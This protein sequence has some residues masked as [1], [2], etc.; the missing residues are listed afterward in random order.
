MLFRSATL[1]PPR[2]YDVADL[3]LN[4]SGNLDDGTR[5][6]LRLLR[7]KEPEPL[8][9]PRWRP[10]GNGGWDLWTDDGRSTFPDIET[11]DPR[12]AL[13]AALEQAAKGRA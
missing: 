12:L 5:A 1:W 8:T 2:E 10:S 6:L 3:A 7:P 13:A 11:K 4:L 9:A